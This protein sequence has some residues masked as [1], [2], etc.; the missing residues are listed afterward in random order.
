MM[1]QNAAPPPITQAFMAMEERYRAIL[2][3][4]TDWNHD[5]VIAEM[6]GQSSGTEE[7]SL[8]NQFSHWK[9]ALQA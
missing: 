8:V 3:H 7:T 1:F 2:N 6:L 9:L 5:Q 4:H